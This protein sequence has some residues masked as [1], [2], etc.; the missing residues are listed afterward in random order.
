MIIS[1]M[2]IYMYRKIVVKLKREDMWVEREVDEFS[3]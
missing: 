2:R 3:R 1:K